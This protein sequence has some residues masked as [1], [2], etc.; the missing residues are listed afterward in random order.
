MLR[1]V[2]ALLLVVLA[3]LVAIALPAAADE[4]DARITSMAI[5][6]ELQADGTLDLHMDLTMRFSGQHGPFLVFGEDT[7]LPTNPNHYQHVT[8]DVTSVSSPTDAPAS[9]AVEHRDHA[10][11]LKIGE[12]GRIVYGEQ[13]YAIAYTLSGMLRPAGSYDGAPAEDVFDWRAIAPG[14]F[15]VPIENFSADIDTGKNASSVT[16]MAGGAGA[17]TPCEGFSTKGSA[18]QL[19]TSVPK[20]EGIRI[21]SAYPAGTF[22]D[23]KLELA[24]R[25]TWAN[26]WGLTPASGAAAA[27]TLIGGVAA[28]VRISRRARLDERYLD[29]PPGVSP[30]TADHPVGRVPT[31]T[32]PVSFTPLTQ[33][34]GLLGTLIDGSADDEDMVATL[35]DLARRGIIELDKRPP[36]DEGDDDYAVRWLDPEGRIETAP[37]ERRFLTTLFKNNSEIAISTEGE[38]LVEATSHLKEDLDKGVVEAG[39]YRSSPAAARATWVG[40]ALLV[41]VA[42]IILGVVTF[43]MHGPFIIPVALLIV[44]FVAMVNYDAAQ[45]RTAEGSVINDQLVGFKDY[46]LAAEAGQLEMGEAAGYYDRL[47]PLAVALGVESQWERACREAMFVTGERLSLPTWYVAGTTAHSLSSGISSAMLSSITA[48]SSSSGGGGVSGGG[49]SMGGGSW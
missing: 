6:G 49:G 39:W 33:R 13:R 41:M 43:L 1:R 12:E 35:F 34:P 16:C 3:M 18:F 30:T 21:V 31:P 32:I 45:V 7:E 15:K 14:G 4:D 26:M 27:V 5:R 25:R 40:I 2:W 36:T 37:W 42:A 28:V 10:T 23:A 22:P 9:Y 20:G 47:L 17:T 11:V 8:F 48:V 29:L 24:P 38:Q 46:V 19:A 44:S